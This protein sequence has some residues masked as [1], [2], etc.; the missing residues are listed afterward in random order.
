M[1]NFVDFE[2]QIFIDEKAGEMSRD[3]LRTLAFCYKELTSEQFEQ[4]H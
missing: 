2:S 3:G 1:N 4:F